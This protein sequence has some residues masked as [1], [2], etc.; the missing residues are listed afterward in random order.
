M[1]EA[2]LYLRNL[3]GNYP[4]FTSIHQDREPQDAFTQKKHVE[5]YIPGRILVV[6]IDIL[7][8]HWSDG[9]TFRHRFFVQKNQLVG[10]FPLNGTYFEG[11]IFWLGGCLTNFE[12][13]ST[14][15]TLQPE[16]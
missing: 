4:Y 5:P 1:D 8:H 3:V 13:S 9:W 11:F 12:T 2:N 16:I 6:E 15:A 7:P 14:S 10:S